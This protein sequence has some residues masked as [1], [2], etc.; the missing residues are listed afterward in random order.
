MIPKGNATS[1]QHTYDARAS[2]WIVCYQQSV[3]NRYLDSGVLV[4]VRGAEQS[5]AN[6]STAHCKILAVHI[7]LSSEGRKKLLLRL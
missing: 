6:W 4:S 7:E 5:P 3:P 2:C 1:P